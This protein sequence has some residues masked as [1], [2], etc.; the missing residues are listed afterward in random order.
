[1]R[2]DLLDIWIDIAIRQAEAQGPHGLD[3]RITAM[4]LICD[5]WYLFSDY[6]DQKPDL[7]GSL[8]ATLRRCSRDRSIAARI[9][10]ISLMFRLLD[11]FAKEK[12]SSAPMLYKS[13]IFTMVESSHE[14]E[15]REHY[16]L[17]FAQLFK[18]IPSIPISL[19]IEPLIKQMLSDKQ[20]FEFK[21]GDFELFKVLS[22]HSKLSMTSA[23]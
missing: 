11:K 21:T 15:I 10:A 23:L 13:L 19:L 4:T 1:M 14:A 8:L 18:A 20:P 5:I 16:L 2:T 3:D 7:S 22:Q 17:N 9:V 6:V 12:N